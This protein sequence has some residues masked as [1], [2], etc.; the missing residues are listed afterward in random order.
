MSRDTHE[1]SWD[2][3]KKMQCKG[4]HGQQKML[5]AEEGKGGRGGVSKEVSRYRGW[6]LMKMES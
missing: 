3:G 5:I 6:V 1:S 2:K 4:G